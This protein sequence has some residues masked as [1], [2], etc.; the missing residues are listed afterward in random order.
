VGL[1]GS[2]VCGPAVAW[3]GGSHQLRAL[4]PFLGFV[5]QTSLSSHLLICL[6]PLRL[7]GIEPSCPAPSFRVPVLE[8]VLPNLLSKALPSKPQGRHRRPLAPLCGC[9]GV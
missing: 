7:W 5:P 6:M 8:L 2:R 1:A 4:S 9:F 3:A